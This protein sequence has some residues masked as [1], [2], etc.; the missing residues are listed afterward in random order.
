MIILAIN[1]IL[2]YIKSILLTKQEN[3]KYPL[4]GFTYKLLFITLL[5]NLGVDVLWKLDDE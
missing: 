4:E 1:K 2:S 3:V 5:C